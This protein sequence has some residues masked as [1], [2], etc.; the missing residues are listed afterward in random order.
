[1]V[2]GRNAGDIRLY[3]LSTCVW[4][5]KTK[6]LFKD[7]GVAYSFLDVD[8]LSDSEKDIVMDEIGKWNPGHNFPTIIIDG[9][10][11]IIGYDE[12]EINKAVK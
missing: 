5:K 3:T 11:A 8:L 7:L 4:C 12:D 1:M 9:K 10:K 2:E 6:K